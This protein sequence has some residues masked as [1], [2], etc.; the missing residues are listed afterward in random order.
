LNIDTDIKYKEKAS[1]R[2]SP[3]KRTFLRS[4]LEF[5]EKISKIEAFSK[6]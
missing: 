5:L 2:S 3:N 1:A 6:E 4:K